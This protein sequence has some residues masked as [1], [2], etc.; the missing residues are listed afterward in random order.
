[1]RPHALGV[2]LRIADI[3]LDFSF[4]LASRALDLMLGAARGLAEF[5]LCLPNKLLGCAFDLVPVHV[6]LQTFF[7]MRLLTNGIASPL[8]H[9]PH[10]GEMPALAWD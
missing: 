3:A 4:D 9:P 1:M 5:F 10:T 8:R 6:N 2:L 7:A